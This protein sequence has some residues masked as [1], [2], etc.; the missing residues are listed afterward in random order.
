MP[1]H[2]VAPF[3]AD[4]RLT[5]LRISDPGVTPAFVPIYAAHER[6]RPPRPAARWLLE[7]LRERLA[8]SASHDSVGAGP[9]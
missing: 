3:L 5:E 9:S 6:S 4:G 2:I 7:N 1:S 8:P